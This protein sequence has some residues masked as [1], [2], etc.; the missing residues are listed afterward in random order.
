MESSIIAPNILIAAGGAIGV[1]AM[2]WT[3]TMRARAD[4]RRLDAAAGRI[5][6]EMSFMQQLDQ[7]LQQANLGVTAGEFLR[8]ILVLG[9]L[10]GLAAW[11]ITGMWAMSVFGFIVGATFYWSYLGERRD[12]KR[13]EY[14]NAL[15]DV[16]ALMIEGFATGNTMDA[17]FDNVAKHGPQVV[18]GDFDNLLAQLSA[19]RPREDV[20]REWADMR[21]DDILDVIVEALLIQQQRGTRASDLLKGLQDSVEARIAIRMRIAAEQMSP[22]W[23]VRITSLFVIGL[24]VFARVIN[25]AYVAFWRTPIGSITLFGAWG[26]A[27]IGYYLSNYIITS[28]SRVEE[29][30]GVVRAERAGQVE[31][32]GPRL[33]VVR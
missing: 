25:P 14:Q 32:T 1:L 5:R 20:L 19:G 31:D 28:A 4:L 2:F 15:A 6:E 7:R 17:A 24:A 13:A 9:V 33:E 27:L 18:R 23:E 22:K 10:L 29:S 11:L 16:I 21:R 3:L 12:K 30:F 26:I 8:T